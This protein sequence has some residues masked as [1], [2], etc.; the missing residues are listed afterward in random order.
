MHDGQPSS[1]A[2]LQAVNGSDFGTLRVGV[3]TDTR[4]E[5]GAVCQ[6]T[7]GPLGNGDCAVRR[8]PQSGAR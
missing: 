7:R 5:V 1:Y 2:L 6:G 3:A 4:A 8:C